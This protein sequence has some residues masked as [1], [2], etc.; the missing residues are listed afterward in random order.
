MIQEKFGILTKDECLDVRLSLRN[1]YS[2]HQRPLPWREH[3]NPYFTWLC[4]IIMQQTRIEQGLNYW[5]HFT[6][7]WPTV[8]DLASAS[9]ESILKAW[10]GLGYYSRARNLHRTAQIV[11]FELGGEFPKT[12]E[13]LQKLPGIGP[14][15]A[16]AIASIAFGQ[17]VAAVDGNVM[18]VISRW[19]EISDPIDTPKG[20]RRIESVAS[21]WVSQ[22]WPGDHNQAVMELGAL[23]CK[24]QSPTC[25]ECPLQFSCKSSCNPGETPSLPNKLGKQKVQDVCVTFDLITDGTHVVMTPRPASGIW[26]G[27]WEFPS[28]WEKSFSDQTTP[29]CDARKWSEKPLVFEGMWGP[30]FVH[31]LSHRR[32]HC[33][34]RVWKA[35][36]LISSSGQV[37]NQEEAHALPIPKALELH[38]E[39][40]NKR[41]FNNS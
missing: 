37:W 13:A 5:I 31:V 29:P 9:E 18:R 1:W 19:A 25:A 8:Q 12:S 33:R 15:T 34:F 26:G 3:S 32:L 4:E 35:S 40:L 22:D 39:E 30:E 23:I 11:A 41:V 24:P 28:T 20:R 10:Q 17:P 27:L 7:T 21:Q 16:S 6:S 14:Y 38:W 2:V 36:A